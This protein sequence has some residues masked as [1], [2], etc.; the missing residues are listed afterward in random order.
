MTRALSRH[1]GTVL[2]VLAAIHT[3][4]GVVLFGDWLLLIA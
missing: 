2:M 1:V 3:V 4:V